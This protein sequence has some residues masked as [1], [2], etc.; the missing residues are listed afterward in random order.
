MGASAEELQLKYG[1]DG[2][3][4]LAVRGVPGLAEARAALLPLAARV[5]A[6]PPATLATYERPKAFYAIGW[7][8]GKEQLE[9]R[10]DLVGVIAIVIAML[11]R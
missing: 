5:A 11:Q 10:P 7:S 3:G 9:G 8:H 1:Y 2:L 6:L 4:I